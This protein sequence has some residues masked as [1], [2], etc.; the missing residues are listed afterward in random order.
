MIESQQAK[1]YEDCKK[2][3]EAFQCYKMALEEY[4]RQIMSIS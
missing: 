4:Y 2:Y 1:K 3:S